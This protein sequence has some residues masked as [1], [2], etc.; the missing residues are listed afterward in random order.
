MTAAESAVSD[1]LT[2]LK[3]QHPYIA[4]NALSVRY[5]ISSDKTITAVSVDNLL[6]TNN[7]DVYD[8]LAV[9]TSN[10]WKY[11]ASDTAGSQGLKMPAC[12]ILANADYKDVFID[13]A[14]ATCFPAS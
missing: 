4:S 10:S 8:A 13:I 2:A 5:L 6:D 12:S 14:P 9:N 7:S 3:A 11:V 1:A